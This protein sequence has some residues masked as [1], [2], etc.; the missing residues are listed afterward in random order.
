VGVPEIF[1]NNDADA[2]LVSYSYKYLQMLK[3]SVFFL[4]VVWLSSQSKKTQAQDLQKSSLI[5]YPIPMFKHSTE[6]STFNLCH[7]Q[8]S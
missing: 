2:Q 8:G 5:L 6:H 1:M 4:K 3:Q 7:H